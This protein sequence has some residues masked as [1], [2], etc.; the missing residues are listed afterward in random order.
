MKRQLRFSQPQQRS[1]TLNRS[2]RQ[3][4]GQGQKQATND[5]RMINRRMQ[6]VRPAGSM[7]R[8]IQRK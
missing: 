2:I 6:I 5:P 7:L 1:I 8:Y 4:Q 3:I